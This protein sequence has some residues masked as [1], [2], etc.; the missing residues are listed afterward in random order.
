MSILKNTPF[1]ILDTETHSDVDP[2]LIQLSY[3]SIWDEKYVSEFYSTGGTPLSLH[4]M[5]VHHIPEKQLEW[6]PVFTGSPEANILASKLK[7]EILVAHNAEFDV[8]VLKNH[9]ID[10]PRAIC[11]LKLS[12]HLYPELEAHKLQYLRYYFGF[13]FFGDDK[14]VAHD[15]LSD[16]KITEALFFRMLEDFEKAEAWLSEDQMIQKLIDISNRPSLLHVCKFGKYKWTLWS[17][18]PKSYLDWVMNGEFDE[19]VMFTAE[20]WSHQK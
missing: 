18:V 8:G 17:D 3:K 12:R 14:I 9:T 6:L 16:V 2:I 19:D 20:Y 1:C 11:T 15:A 4:A 7:S 5:A 10:T 13:D